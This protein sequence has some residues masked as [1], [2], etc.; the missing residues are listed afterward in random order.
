MAVLLRSR[1]GN[2]ALAAIGLVYTVSALVI[3]CWYVAG[4]WHAAGTIDRLLQA[5]LLVS[6]ACG[7]WFIDIATR[8]LGLRGRGDSAS[9][10]RRPRVHVATH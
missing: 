10:A 4:T 3:L 6:F 7:V 8:N 5:A 2:V 9:F 1:I